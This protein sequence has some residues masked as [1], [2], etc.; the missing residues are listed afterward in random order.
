[1]KREKLMKTSIS[2]PK[3]Q[4]WPTIEHY[5]D[6]TNLGSLIASSPETFWCYIH[7]AD[8]PLF[9]QSPDP[10]FC[11]ACNAVLTRNREDL[12]A[13]G[14][15]RKPW[16]VPQNGKRK[17]KDSVRVEIQGPQKMLAQKRLTA[18]SD[19]MDPTLNESKDKDPEKGIIHH[20]P[21]ET[22]RKRPHLPIKRN[23]QL[24]FDG[25]A[26]K[27]AIRCENRASPN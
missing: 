20:H 9:E 2:T 14:N 12:R 24:A 11:I 23:K 13:S 22:L 19:K 15:F 4:L 25:M 21:L 6:L 7:L 17:G 5:R 3:P 27:E 26:I 10:R 8:M 1:M 18:L 16:W